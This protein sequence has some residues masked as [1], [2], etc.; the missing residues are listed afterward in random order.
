MTEPGKSQ[1]YTATVLNRNDNQ[2]PKQPVTV[3]ISLKVDPTSGGHDHGDSSRPRGGIDGTKCESDES[4]KTFIT[5]GS[6]SNGVV[7]FTFDA[8][9]ASGTHTITATCDRCSNSDSKEVDVKVAGLES[10][11]ASQFYTFIGD[12]NNHSANHYLVSEAATVLWRMAVSYHMEAKY[13]QL[14]TLRK[15]R[16][17]WAVYLPPLPL[18]VNDASLIWGG[19]FDTK[20]NW[21]SP[22]GK[23]RR[24]VVIDVR[25][26]SNTGA[27]PL[28]S[29][30][31]FKK[32]A[33]SYDGAVAQV[34]CTV[35]PGRE[36]PSCVSTIDGSQDSNRH[37]HILL[38]G[39][40]E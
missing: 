36:P 29:F 4:C 12:N 5:G 38:L 11:P 17:S 18:Q 33:A 21:A 28:A 40:D 32:M 23:H 19:R 26:N 1:T 13:Q 9:E 34:H 24:G 3:K 31:N 14:K 20:G 39:V 6:G 15:W 2:P 7:T 30:A 10:I 35:A 37:M 22:H 27:I 25:A 8:P 16:R